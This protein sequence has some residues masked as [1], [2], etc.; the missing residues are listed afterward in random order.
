MINHL[1][2]DIQPVILASASPRRA[3][4]LRQIG[5][6]FHIRPSNVEEPPPAEMEMGPVQIA[7]HLALLKAE[8]VAANQ[9]RGLVIGSDTVVWNTETILG[10]PA[11]RREAFSMLSALS[12]KRHTVTTGVALI[13]KP[14][15]TTL[16]F[17]TST[18]VFFRDLSKSEISDYI[19]TGEPMDKAGGYGI[20]GIGA[21]LVDHIDGDYFN[22]VG[23]PLTAF[24]QA[25]EKLILQINPQS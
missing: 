2:S 13:Y 21:L 8:N 19:D 12:K 16:V 17:H 23:F 3:D 15:R 20:Q 22:V 4:L 9:D 7:E 5:M 24:Y 11:D 18:R 14:N 6:E 25:L 1:L 10:K